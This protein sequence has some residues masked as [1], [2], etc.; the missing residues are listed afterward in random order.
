MVIN[1]PGHTPPVR[2]AP[3]SIQAQIA[4]SVQ[5]GFTKP[6]VTITGAFLAVAARATS[7]TTSPAAMINLPVYSPAAAGANSIVTEPVS[8][9]VIAK[10][11]PSTVAVASS[12][13]TSSYVTV[14]EVVS[15]SIISANS[16]ADTCRISGTFGASGATAVA[17]TAT[18]SFTSPEVI[19]R[20]PVYSPSASGAK[21]IV[22]EPTDCSAIEK[23]SPSIVA[24][25]SVAFS[26]V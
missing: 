24:V 23:P 6:I 16:A 25:A 4:A 3:P 11:S 2:F 10:P 22:T 15:P 7:L 20:V 14:T 17:L 19:V 26:S 1:L 5:S 9:A 18:V 13:L 8:C 12:A 21:V